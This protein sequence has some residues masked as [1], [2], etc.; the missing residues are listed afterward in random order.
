M[1]LHFLLPLLLFPRTYRNV[2]QPLPKSVLLFCCRRPRWNYLRVDYRSVFDFTRRFWFVRWFAGYRFFGPTISIF[3]FC[4]FCLIT[5]FGLPT[6]AIYVCGLIS[7]LVVLFIAGSADPA[8][9]VG[10]LCWTVI[11]VMPYLFWVRGVSFCDWWWLRYFV[12]QTHYVYVLVHSWWLDRYADGA[13]FVRCPI[14]WFCWGLC[15]YL[16]RASMHYYIFVVWLLV[17]C[18][19]GYRYR[20]AAWFFVAFSIVPLRTPPCCITIGVHGAGY[21][22]SVPGSCFG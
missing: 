10:H 9:C 7:S 20:T 16:I 17:I 12:D 2:S 22:L 13:I 18:S 1:K 6:A 19:D 11:C 3:A 5:S 4:G 15:G 8:C 21:I 14:R